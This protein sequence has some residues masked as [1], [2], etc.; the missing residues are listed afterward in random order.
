MDQNF[1][2]DSTDERV[3]FSYVL[4]NPS[5]DLSLKIGDIM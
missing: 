5:Y 3:E 4:I 1:F 2:I